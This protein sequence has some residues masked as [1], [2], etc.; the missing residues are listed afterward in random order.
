MKFVKAARFPIWTLLANEIIFLILPAV[1]ERVSCHGPRCQAPVPLNL[2]QSLR[3]LPRILNLGVWN[4]HQPEHILC[5]L[6]VS[7]VWTPVSI[8]DRVPDE[9]QFNQQRV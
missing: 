9:W 8:Y 2:E 5:V 3:P 6:S 4:F 7:N 1:Q